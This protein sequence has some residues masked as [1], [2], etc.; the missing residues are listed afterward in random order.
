MTFSTVL[1]HLA[2]IPT[3]EPLKRPQ[4][5]LARARP[6]ADF[7]LVCKVQFKALVLLVTHRMTGWVVIDFVACKGGECC[8]VVYYDCD[9][10]ETVHGYEILI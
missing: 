7:L 9:V 8:T 2:F 10:L 3:S 4:K 6:I 1:I 5:N